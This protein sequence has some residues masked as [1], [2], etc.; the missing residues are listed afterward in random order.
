MLSL[1]TWHG[2]NRVTVLPDD[3][4]ARLPILPAETAAMPEAGNW[5]VRISSA[6]LARSAMLVGGSQVSTT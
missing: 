4:Y 3:G 6:A 2:K 1:Q 5:V